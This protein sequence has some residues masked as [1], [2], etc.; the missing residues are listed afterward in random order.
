MS[1][2]TKK[3]LI[4]E[5][6]RV[7]KELLESG[8]EF[9]YHYFPR[10]SNHYVDLYMR[11]VKAIDVEFKQCP[12][13]SSTRNNG[14]GFGYDTPRAIIERLHEESTYYIGKKAN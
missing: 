4:A 9:F 10:N 8:S 3:D 14:N 2:I 13:S 7:N 5:I 11:N 6:E 1:R 12:H